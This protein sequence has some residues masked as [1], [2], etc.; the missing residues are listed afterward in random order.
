M[1]SLR[2]QCIAGDNFKFNLETEMVPVLGLVESQFNKVNK[3]NDAENERASEGSSIQN[4][5]HSALLNLL[6]KELKVQPNQIHDF[7]LCVSP[8]ASFSSI[9]DR[10]IRQL[11]DT[12]PSTVGGL[13]NE[14]IFSPRLDNL[15]SSWVP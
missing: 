1:F 8:C 7:E 14:F 6:A 12:Q 5:H 2:C 15:F 13:H 9:T 3:S 11:Y 4:N 10:H